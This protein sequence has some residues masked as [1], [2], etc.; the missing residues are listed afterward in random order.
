MRYEI[1]GPLRVV[2]GHNHSFISAQKVETL[3]AV[4]LICAEQI[5]SPTQLM[6]ELWGDQLPKRATAG[7]HVYISQL[8]KFLHRPHRQQNPVVTQQTGYVLRM[9]TDTLDL[10]T[11]SDLAAQGRALAKDHCYEPAADRFE[12]ALSLWHG[13]VLANLG[14]GPIIDGFTTWLTET[15]M[16]CQEMLTDVHLH[17]GRHR[18]LI[19]PLYSLTC[20]YPLRETLYRQLML[21]L[22][23]SERKADALHVYQRARRTLNDELGL[24]PCRALR[25]LHQAVLAD[26]QRLSLLA[27]STAG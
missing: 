2:D 1:L 21:A 17:L 22:Y 3:F 16:E 18:E 5:V 6:K 27:V 8:R 23:R 13:P 15:R 9:G 11:F 25:D 4:L 10:H 19:G 20:E 12:R 26:D 14:N 7:L 24:E